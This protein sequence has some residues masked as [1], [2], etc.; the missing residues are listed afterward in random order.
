MKR[1]KFGNSVALTASSLA[2]LLSLA[3][4]GCGGGSDGPATAPVSGT[5]TVKGAP[6]GDLTVTFYS[7]GGGRPAIG[8]T[9]ADGEFSL[10]TNNTGDG[11]TVGSHKAAVSAGGSGEEASAPPMPGFPGYNEWMKKQRELI[12]PKYADPKTSGL[13]YTV[14]AEGLTDIE[15]KIP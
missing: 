13:T 15:I 5:V 7:E 6:R 8:I 4:T 3:A 11:A 9:D 2:L 1:L 14:P 10:T 12:D